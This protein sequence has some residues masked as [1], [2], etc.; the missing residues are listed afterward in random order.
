M[1]VSL[2]DLNNIKIVTNII[3]PCATQLYLSLEIVVGW[4]LILLRGN[5]NF[6]SNN[7]YSEVMPLKYNF[8]FNENKSELFTLQKSSKTLMHIKAIL[9]QVISF[10]KAV[11]K[12]YL[13]SLVACL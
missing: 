11:L 6:H 2:S 5:N 13:M 12:D 3:I 8:N 7:K 4:L 1:S 9:F 10:L